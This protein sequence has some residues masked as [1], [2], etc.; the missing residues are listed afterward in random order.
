MKLLTFCLFWASAVMTV[1]ALTFRL[2][3][4]WAS[5]ASSASRLSVSA[6]AGSAPF[7]GGLEILR[8]RGHGRP[9]LVDDQAQALLVGQAQD[10][11]NQVGRD[12]RLGVAG[13]IVAPDGS[14]LPLLPGWQ[15][16]KYSPISDW[17]RDWQ[18]ASE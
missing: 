13:R 2:L 18:K 14:T 4:V 7:E 9:Q 15:S 11:L 12:R 17:G 3:I 5:L 8:A 1:L 6:S 10:V 16:T